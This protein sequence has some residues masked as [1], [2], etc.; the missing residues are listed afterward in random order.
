MFSL[1]LLI[2]VPIRDALRRVFISKDAANE[3][4]ENKKAPFSKFNGID[5]LF[6]TILIKNNIIYAIIYSDR[7]KY[8]INLNSKDFTHMSKIMAFRP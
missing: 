7:F 2:C 5:Y 1:F 8:F 4:K 6:A 3:Q